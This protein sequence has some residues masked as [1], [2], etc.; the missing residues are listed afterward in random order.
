[1][2]KTSGNAPESVLRPKFRNEDH[3]TASVKKAAEVLGW[4]AYHPFSKVLHAS[5]RKR[6]PGLRVTPGYP[7]LT[8]IRAP[9][10]IFAEL[11]MPGN[12]PT[13]AQREWGDEIMG[14][15]AEY[16]LWRPD[17]WDDILEILQEAPSPY[18]VG[19]RR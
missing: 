4:K 1:M 6:S 8:L 12:Y 2:K 9:R 14:T 5:K 13:E 19:E 17:H 10:I 18:Q 15:P 11:K 3:F 16:Y 7:D